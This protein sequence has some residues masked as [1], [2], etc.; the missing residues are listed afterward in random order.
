MVLLVAQ[1]ELESESWRP[2][3]AVEAICRSRSDWICLIMSLSLSLCHSRSL[4]HSC[5]EDRCLVTQLLEELRSHIVQRDLI[6]VQ[7]CC[8]LLATV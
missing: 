6:Q 2:N 8:W 3:T 4:S 5:S 7:N 1:S